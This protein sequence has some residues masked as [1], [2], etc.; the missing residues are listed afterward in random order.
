MYMKIMIS[1]SQ[2]DKLVKKIKDGERFIKC[3][4]CNKLFTQ[5]FHKGKK[6]LPI[7]PWCGRH[8][9]QFNENQ[10]VEER[11]RSFAFTRKKRLFSKP[12][13]MANPDRYKKHDKDLKEINR[14]K[15][16]ELGP[17]YKK[18]DPEENYKEYL[19]VKENYP[20]D[21]EVGDFVYHYQIF[22]ED[23]GNQM[24]KIHVIDA[25]KKLK[26]GEGEFEMRFAGQF[27][28][29]LPFIRKEY[30]NQGIAMEMYKT[31]LSFGEIISGKAQSDQAVGLWKKMMRELSN[32]VVFVDDAGKEHDAVF[33]N[34]DIVVMNTGESVY[35]EKM[36][37]YLKMY[38]A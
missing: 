1:E 2:F 31:I 21:K 19:H 23:G 8:N 4:S 34:D 24:V 38:Q 37:G 5:T 3:D 30:R 32:K 6:S 27:F 15:F 11:S 29:T 14:Y 7:C 26:V 22:D 17:K 28:V 16:S 13:M 10:E 36:G 9:V 35:G 25:L 33:K 12:E 18:D 20:I